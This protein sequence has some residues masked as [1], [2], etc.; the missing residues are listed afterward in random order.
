MR[1]FSLALGLLVCLLTSPIP[2]YSQH[3][4]DWG[5]IPE[6][7]IN[8]ASEAGFSLDTASVMI[9]MGDGNRQMTS[10]FNNNGL[11]KQEITYQASSTAR[12]EE[13]RAGAVRRILENGEPFSMPNGPSGYF[14]ESE[15]L[16]VSVKVNGKT[17]KWL[18]LP[19]A[20]F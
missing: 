17:V 8:I 2:A 3:F 6:D 4:G 1:L 9:K 20:R 16:F 18:M 13:A 7:I 11:W 12:A 15:D 14:I 5:D 10:H 19:L